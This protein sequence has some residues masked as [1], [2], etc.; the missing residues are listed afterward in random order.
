MISNPSILLPSKLKIVEEEATKGIYEVE[1]LYPGY[2]H[3]LG[4][5]LRRIILSS[6]PGTAV[7]A[8]KIKGAD[9]EFSTIAGV[10]EDVITIL[11]NLKKVHFE[12][13]TDEP[14]TLTLKVA[15]PAQVTASM[16]TTAGDIKVATP[17][18]Y[19]CEVTDKK[20]T[21]EMEITIQRGLGYVSRE[22]LFPEKVPVGTITLDATFSPIRKVSYE[23]ENMRVGDRTDHNRLRLTVHTDGSITPKAVF[24]EATKTM[25]TQL[26]AI[27]DLKDIEESLPRIKKPDILTTTHSGVESTDGDVSESGDPVDMADI[28]KTRVDTLEL[29]TR[30]QNALSEANM[31]TVGSLVKKKKD[32]LLEIPGLGSKAVEEI[33]ESLEN[34]GVSLNNS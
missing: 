12:M 18:Q 32:D 31:R 25:L 11:L 15:G 17:D 20:T 21:L 30:T 10:K 8:V 3:T 9:H 16:I 19:I 7:T 34:L 26:Q 5:S 2:G 6:L 24:E 23:V 22:I 14:Q 13:H 29:S 28:L 27:I 33:V 1:G 4:N